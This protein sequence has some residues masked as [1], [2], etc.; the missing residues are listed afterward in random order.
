MVLRSTTT[1]GFSEADV[2]TPRVLAVYSPKADMQVSADASYFSLGAVLI[3]KWPES[4][5]WKPAVF[6]SRGLSDAEKHYVHIE[7]EALA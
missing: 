4:S 7:K 2:R 1:R 5:D 3:Q 6:I